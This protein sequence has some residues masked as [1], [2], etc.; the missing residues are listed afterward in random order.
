M[1]SRHPSSPQV[2]SS[3]TL[4][5][6]S[7]TIEVTPGVLTAPTVAW[8]QQGAC[9]LMAWALA[10]QAAQHGHEWELAIIGDALNWG[11]W[12]HMGAVTEDQR[13]FVDAGGATDVEQV[14][15]QWQQQH[16]QRR[17][18]E[19]DTALRAV[20]ASFFHLIWHDPRTVDPPTRKV[21]LGFADHILTTEGFV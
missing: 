17:H 8:F 4:T 6:G 12:W 14:C 18:P 13:Y 1:N 2:G 9:P 20:Q 21:T 7:F 19:R 15:E 11:D 10:H 16:H 5:Y 3:T